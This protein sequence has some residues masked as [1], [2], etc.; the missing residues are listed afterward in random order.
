MKVIPKFQK[1]GFAN[2]FTIYQPVKVPELDTGTT[3]SKESSSSTTSTKKKSSD[4]DDTKGKLTE[5]DFFNMIKDIDGLPN[6]MTAIV[7][8]LTRTF[9][10]Q[11]IMGLD[12]NDL[13]TT[14]LKNLLQIKIAAQNKDK[15]DEAWKNA[16]TNGSMAEPAIALNGDIVV[17]TQDGKLTN[18]GLDTYFNNRDKYIPL[19]VSQLL[20]LRAHSSATNWDQ[21]IFN[22][23]N[24]S[25]GYES[26]QALLDKAKTSLG[27]NQY[28]EKGMRGKDALLGLQALSGLSPEQKEKYIQWAID[29]V[30][31]YEASSNTNVQQI[32]ALFSYLSSVL[33]K[34]AKTWAAIK[35]GIANPET[36]TRTL[37][38]VYLK[39]G[40]INNNSY[41]VSYAGSQ[42]KL[43][44]TNGKSSGGIDNTDAGFWTQLQAGQGGDDMPY[45]ILNGKGFQS[46]TGKYYGTT[47]GLDNNKSLGDYISDSKLGYL[48]KNTHDITFG[49][50]P[51]STD[52]FNDVMVNAASGVMAVTLPIKMDGTVDL[53]VVQKWEQIQT[54]LKNEKLQVGSDTYNKRMSQLL[55]D[56]KLDT[57]LASNGMPNPNRF[58]Y[59]LVLTGLTSKRAKGVTNSQ[60]G[61][62]KSFEDIDSDWI[63]N[64]GNDNSTYETL[65]QGLANKDRGEYDAKSA[66]YGTFYNDDLYKGNIYIPLNI[67]P[68]NAKNADDSTISDSEARI[69]ERLTQQKS[70][71][72]SQL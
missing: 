46:V 24:N 17:Q 72:S 25:M 26:F 16:A 61:E 30:Y 36:A 39:S 28:S 41:N 6:E 27:S 44:G 38:G 60:N 66:G 3:K 9:Q 55:K 2:Y 40:E 49:D 35:T 68:I 65:K 7:S 19:S 42:E 31:T 29:G 21:R 33:P 51:L 23:V 57:L 32:Q 63:I 54:L 59:F 50:I 11:N 71:K 56:A 20:N 34:R 8:N 4:D 12:T 18:I 10:L 52:S 47:P 14:Y 53:S 62:S 64:A 22:I 58:G 70:T 15:Y 37:I 5:K 48:I 67:N 43:L 45:T 13:A 1:G 69:Y